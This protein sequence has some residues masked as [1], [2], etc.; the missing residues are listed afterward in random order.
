MTKKLT[1]IDEMFGVIN[2]TDSKQEIDINLLDAYKDHDF[3][4][5]EGKQLESMVESIKDLGILQPLL[6]RK[7]DGGRYEIL[8]GHNRTKAA[9]IAGLNTVPVIVL[10]TDDNMA[11]IIVTE[12]NLMQRGFGELKVSEQ[13]KILEKHYNKLKTAGK[14]TYLTTDIDKAENVVQD[15]FVPESRE[16]LGE[17]YGLTGRDISR[18]LRINYLSNRLKRKVD[19]KELAFNAAVNL[20]FLDITNQIILCRLQEELNCKIDLKKS[21]KLKELEK[22]GKLINHAAETLIM[23]VLKGLYDKPEAKQSSV[24]MKG[25]K[26]KRDTLERYFDEESTGDD[27]KAIIDT[28]LEM[29]FNNLVEH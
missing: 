19:N 7:K 20:S 10:D 23:L 16:M 29:Y 6:V 11:E 28:A 18:L 9:K 22:E 5:Y 13:A 12:T 21:V 1:S 14:R 24:L 2:D 3:Q 4:T 8:A 26:I 25:Y 15:K 27:I 17:E